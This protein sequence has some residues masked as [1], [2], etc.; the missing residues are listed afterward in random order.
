MREPL[1][2]ERSVRERTGIRGG[3]NASAAAP[4]GDDEQ[5][6]E[7]LQ[8]VDEGMHGSSASP[9]QPLSIDRWL[10][11]LAIAAMIATFLVLPPSYAMTLIAFI[12]LV[13]TRLNASRRLLGLTLTEALAWVAT[14]AIV[15][16]LS[17]VVIVVLGGSAGA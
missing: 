10:P 3:T 17:L 4:F 11:I 16:F 5:R 7:K 12:W 15:A 13:G 8:D 6:V 1:D 9:V 14:V 2:G